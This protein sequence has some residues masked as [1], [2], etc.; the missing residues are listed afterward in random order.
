[1]NRKSSHEK[2]KLMS[3]AKAR[4]CLHELYNELE[5]SFERNKLFGQQYYRYLSILREL[6]DDPD[7]KKV[8]EIGFGIGHMSACIKK[9]GFQ[10]HCV[11]LTIDKPHKRLHDYKIPLYECDIEREKLPF[12]NKSFDIILFN[13]VIEH[14]MDDPKRTLEQLRRVLKSSGTIIMTTPN[15]LY[16]P[17]VVYPLLGKNVFPILSEYYQVPRLLRLREVYDRHNRLYTMSEAVDVMS[18]AGLI[19]QEKK[20][21]ACAEP[22]IKIMGKLEYANTMRW[23]HIFNSDWLKKVIYFCITAVFPPWRSW[24]MVKAGWEK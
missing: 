7:G 11:D 3:S 12:E 19:V 14:L 5:D 23:R 8:L 2:K 21:L 4:H 13:D 24:I 1:M 22:V 9:L 15:V 17:L 20:F 10:L 18:Q 6:P 16:L